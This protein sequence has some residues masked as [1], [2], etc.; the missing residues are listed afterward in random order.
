[1]MRKLLKHDIRD[2]YMEIVIFCGLLIFASLLIMLAVRTASGF[3][4][5]ISGFAYFA[6]AAILAV[7]LIRII[8]QNFHVKMFTNIGYLTLTT[9][10]ST[11]K[12][13]LSK[14][15]VSMLWQTVVVIAFILSI[16]IMIGSADLMGNFLRGFIRLF[17]DFP[18]QSIMV[19]LLILSFSLTSIMT[20]LLV[21]AIINKG[22]SKRYKVLKGILIYYGL[23]Q[24]IGS[25]VAVLLVWII[26][27]L[28]SGNNL[29][30]LA[31]FYIITGTLLVA[32]LGI[33][34][35]FYFLSRHIIIKKIELE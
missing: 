17:V 5:F 13:L 27:P 23:N 34:V 35:G 25:F 4:I 33:S 3:F 29:S 14:I 12:L 15:I 16:L 26:F 24:A 8:I 32:F 9:P 11:D 7:V 20:L 19:C 31:F 28:S 10:V 30:P 21:L 2:S 18:A 1:M 22:K 6:A